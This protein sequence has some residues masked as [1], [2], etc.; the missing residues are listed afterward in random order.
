MLKYS[1]APYKSRPRQI[2]SYEL[3]TILA[4][5]FSN[6]LHQNSFLLDLFRQNISFLLKVGSKSS[7]ST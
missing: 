7:I 3:L 6:K 2:E 1:R 4:T 5:A